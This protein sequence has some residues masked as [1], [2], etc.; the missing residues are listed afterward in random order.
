MAYGDL[1]IDA[2]LK[3]NKGLEGG[4][5]NRRACQAEPALWYNHGSRSWYCEDCAND[6]GNDVV[7]ARNWP[8]DFERL[9]PN[10]PFHPM[11]ETREM[12]NARLPNGG[13]IGGYSADLIIIDEASYVDNDL[14]DQLLGP[15]EIPAHG[16]RP[17]RR[18]RASYAGAFLASTMLRIGDDPPMCPHRKDTELARRPHFTSSKPLTK[19]QLRR[20]KGRK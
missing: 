2:A 4:A 7:N 15:E 1:P 14:L 6:I 20:Q 12:L 17:Y 18:G 16:L 13:K 19:R 9:F 11:F 5:C 8:I 10:R 3:P